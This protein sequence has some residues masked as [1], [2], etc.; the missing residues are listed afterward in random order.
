MRQGTPVIGQCFSSG[1]IHTMSHRRQKRARQA[2]R[3]AMTTVVS[4]EAMLAG[5]A[6]M[7]Q[8]AT[9][10][11]TVAKSEDLQEIVVTGYRASLESALDNKRN[12]NQAIE[13]IAPEDIGKMPDQN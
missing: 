7:A 3:V 6:V 2:A 10:A 5:R 1:G 13:S 8:T 11:T 9:Q 12:S 4:I